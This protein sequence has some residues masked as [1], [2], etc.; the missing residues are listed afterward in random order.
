MLHW[1][2]LDSCSPLWLHS[3][4]HKAAASQ[5]KSYQSSRRTVRTGPPRLPAG[6]LSTSEGKWCCHTRSGS[7]KSASPGRPSALAAAQPGRHQ[8]GRELTAT[9]G[10]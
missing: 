6:S 8:E 1:F 9:H 4:N 10:Q 7:S 3:M 2:Q 5:R